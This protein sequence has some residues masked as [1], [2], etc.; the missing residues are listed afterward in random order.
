MKEQA[1][2]ETEKKK[3]KIEQ[4]IESSS[5]TNLNSQFEKEDPW[6]NNKNGDLSNT[7]K[8]QESSDS[9]EIVNSE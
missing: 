1:K 4:E 9:E 5:D 3:K 8:K 2:L 7:D 6:M